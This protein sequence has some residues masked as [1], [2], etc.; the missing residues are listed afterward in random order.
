LFHATHNATV[1]P[2]GFAVAVLHLPQ[3]EILYV[4]GALVTLAAA[5]IIIATRGRLG[6]GATPTRTTSGSAVASQ[7]ASTMPPL[8]G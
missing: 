4:L 6:S 2:T 8:A 3:G 7:P 1:N 5:G